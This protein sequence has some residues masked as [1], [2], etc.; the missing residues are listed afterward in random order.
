MQVQ[1]LLN[2]LLLLVASGFVWTLLTQSSTTRYVPRY[3]S[4]SASL[5]L[6][7]VVAFLPLCCKVSLSLSFSHHLLFA[8]LPFYC[9]V[10][11]EDGKLPL[12]E[13]EKEKVQTG[14]TDSSKP[15]TLFQS[16][17]GILRF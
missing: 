11:E 15:L 14:A 12:H 5:I 3:F 10:D 9:K 16:P 1:V 4:A 8:L 2:C 17:P 7:L 6:Y 13:Q